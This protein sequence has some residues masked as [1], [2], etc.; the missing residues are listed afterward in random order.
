MN[1]EYNLTAR[2]SALIIKFRESI[3]VGPQIR[4]VM[5]NSEFDTIMTE[6]EVSAWRS[7]KFLCTDFLG[8]R[9]A[10]KFSNLV[11][12][13]LTSYRVLG[14][15]MSLKVHFLHVHLD[16]FHP[17]S[18]ISETSMANVSIRK[19]LKWKNATKESGIRQ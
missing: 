18:V 16:F 15:R 17:T 3:F 7:F 4:Q 19:S 11:E 5:S 1:N 9:K 12:N 2:A 14:C 13:L 6:S 8:N 10:S